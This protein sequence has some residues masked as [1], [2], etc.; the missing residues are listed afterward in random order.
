MRSAITAT[1]AVA[2]CLVAT[3]MLGVASAEAP[4]STAP[5]PTVSV[6]GVAQVPIAQGSNAA[7]ADAAYRQAMAAAETDGQSKAEYLAGK[8]SVTLGAVQ[9]IVEGGGSIACSGGES[10]TG[11]VEYEGEQPD[12]GS[13]VVTAVAPEASAVAH[14]PSVRKPSAK[15]SKKKKPTAHK[16]GAT[17]CTLSAEVSLT[18]AIS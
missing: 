4:T 17:S 14:A 6:D 1:L 2:A 13:R 7:S 12:F 3:G 15:R 11:Y 16:A 18:Y 8:A 5:T 10:E 9:S